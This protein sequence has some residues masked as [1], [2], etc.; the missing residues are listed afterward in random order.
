MNDQ[1]IISSA[2]PASTLE[3]VLAGIAADQILTCEFDERMQKWCATTYGVEGHESTAFGVG[4]TLAAALA[5]LHS[6]IWTM[7]RARDAGLKDWATEDEP[8]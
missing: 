6:P 2:L 5:D 1:S 7:K 4:T 8:E 3:S